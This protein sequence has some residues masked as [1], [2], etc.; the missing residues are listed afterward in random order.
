M[1]LKIPWSVI[2]YVNKS[3]MQIQQQIVFIIG[4]LISVSLQQFNTWTV[5]LQGR[6][7]SNANC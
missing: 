7:N 5:L 3:Q 2:V 1:E 6:P 4:I